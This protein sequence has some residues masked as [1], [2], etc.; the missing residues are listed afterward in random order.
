MAKTIVKRGSSS[1][2]RFVMVEAELGDG[3]NLTEITRAISAALQPAQPGRRL[4]SAPAPQP[5]GDGG[6]GVGA[7]DEVERVEDVEEIVETDSPRTG[8]ARPKISNPKVLSDVDLTTGEMPFQTFAEQKG[9][10]T[11]ELQRYLLVAYWFK[12]YRDTPS[13]TQD[14]VY[15]C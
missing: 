13:V 12:K 7:G 4:I 11:K 1:R 14:H 2:I 8:K 9:P 3:E 10:P 6:N 5:E 15:T